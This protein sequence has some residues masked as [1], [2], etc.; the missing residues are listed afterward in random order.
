MVRWILR[1]HRHE[2]QDPSKP[3]Q[4]ERDSGEEEYQSN[5]EDAREVAPSGLTRV[6]TDKI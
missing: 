1:H 4:A 3:P 6:K 2:H 5:E